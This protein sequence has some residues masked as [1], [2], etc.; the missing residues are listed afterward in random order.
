MLLERIDLYKYYGLKRKKGALGYL[1]TYIAENSPELNLKRKRP[2]MI[3]LP[4]GG[5]QM[6]S[7]REKEPIAIK[8]LEKG[9]SSFTLE[10]SVKTL[11]FPTQLIETAMAVAYIRENAENF[12]VDREH[13]AVVG[14]SAGGHLAATIATLYNDDAVKKTL[15]EYASLARPDAV[16]LGYPVITSDP[17]YW[18]ESSILTVAAGKKSLIQKLSIEKRVSQDSVPAF[19]WHTKEDGAVPVFNSISLASAYAEHGVPF[20]LHVFERGPHG[21]SLAT[22]ETSASDQN[23]LCSKNV[24]IWPELADNW[25]KSRGFIII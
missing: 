20:E 14:F 18:H 1:N 17:K 15:G 2:A 21:M 19:I 22:I 13:I 5:Y 11:G 24:A 4:G 8:F 7:D 23:K 16:I 12:F 3:V 10:Y 9:Y 25:L 6:L